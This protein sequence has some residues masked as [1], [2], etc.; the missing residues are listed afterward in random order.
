MD[1]LSLADVEVR[2]KKVFVRV[3]FNVPLEAGSIA[4][5]T[6]IRAALP[7]LKALLA[8]EATLVVASHLGRPKGGPNPKE[9]L[10]PIAA[11]LQELLGR[12][13]QFVP[14]VVG[15]EVSRRVA[16]LLPGQVLM[17]E[18]LRFD[19]GEEKNDA[20]FARALAQGIEVYV[21][22][23]FGCVHR[24]HASVAAITREVPVA[25]MGLLVRKEVEALR[26]VMERPHKPMALI[27]G[28]A[29]V[30]DKIPLIEGLLPKVDELLIGGGMAYTFL[31]ALGVSVGLSRV[32]KDSLEAAG[33]VLD[34][35]ER[36][37]IEVSLPVDHIAAAKPEAGIAT[38]VAES[39]E[40]PADLMGLDIG[41]ITRLRFEE[42]IAE[43]RTMVWNGPMG[44]FEIPE[45]AQGTIA[46]AQAVAASLGYSLVG[47]GDSVAALRLAG[48]EE[49]IDHVSTGGGATLE[50]LAGDKLPG[51]EALS[52]RKAT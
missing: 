15:P 36:R 38:Q 9:S 24:A 49:R 26:R 21:D 44:V 41:P 51:L 33:K 16:A 1:K 13:V 6:R 27:L 7:T 29:K 2:G 42:K 31:A 32:E 45:F 35:A 48:V 8:A 11:R 43:S 50:F 20:T 12:E 19:K 52:D 46:V 18:N 3:D 25:V 17:L 37:G 14:E 4:D 39:D 22:D 28:G 34:E 30:A 47:G 40:F 5:D 23:A 10:A